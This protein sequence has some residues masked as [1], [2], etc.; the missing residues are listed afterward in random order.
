M[1]I[2]ARVDMKKVENS[3]NIPMIINGQREYFD[4][5]VSISHTNLYPSHPTS[6]IVDHF[7]ALE[8]QILASKSSYIPRKEGEQSLSIM[9]TRFGHSKP[10]IPPMGLLCDALE[11]NNEEIPSQHEETCKE[12]AMEVANLVWEDK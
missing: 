2:G 5:I 11:V 3:K 9:T 6:H 10:N 8:F 12:N 4:K 7:Y 1:G